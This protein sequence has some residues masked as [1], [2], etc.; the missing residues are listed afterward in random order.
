MSRGRDEPGQ[1]TLMLVG[2]FLVLAFLA[3]AVV[4][5]SAAYLRRESLNSL[6][7]GAALAAA[8]GVQAEQVYTEG[9]GD[10]AKVDPQAAA[11]YVADY[12]VSTG[13]LAHYPGLTWSVRAAGDGLTV[14]V[15]AP[16]RLPITPP[17]WDAV[18]SVTGEASVL[19]PVR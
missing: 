3:A 8:D 10:V 16:L 17:G 2:F 6:A 15:D 11:G 7:D 9:L 5:A 19:V 1:V 4:D 18:T 14:H 12:L 13:A